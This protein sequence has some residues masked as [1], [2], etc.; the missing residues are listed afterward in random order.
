MIVIVTPTIMDGRVIRWYDNEAAVEQHDQVASASR[1]AV[2]FYRDD[3]PAHVRDA[4]QGAHRELAKNRDADVRHY[5]T[6]TKTLFGPLV[7]VDREA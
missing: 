5:A 3:I 2:E 7:P 6:H 4:A 1:N